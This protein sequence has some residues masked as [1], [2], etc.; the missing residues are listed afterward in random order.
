MCLYVSD[1]ILKLFSPEILNIDS[2]PYDSIYLKLSGHCFSFVIGCIYRPPAGTSLNS[3]ENDS[4]FYSALDSCFK[5][6]S[7]IVL[8]GDFNYPN[9]KWGNNLYSGTN[10]SENDFI[11]TLNSNNITQLVYQPTRFRQF[12]APS[13]LDLVLT[14]DPG[15]VSRVECGC[16]VG[17]SDHCSIE[18]DIQV[19]NYQCSKIETKTYNSISYDNVN[20]HLHA[21]DWSQ[22]YQLDGIEL[23]WNYFLSLIK[24][25]VKQNTRVHQVSRAFRKPWISGSLI[26]RVRH[27][28]RLWIRYKRTN[29]SDDYSLHRLFANQLKIDINDAREKFQDSLTDR[30]KAFYGYLRKHTASRVSRPILRNSM[31]NLCSSDSEAA[32]LLA[33]YFASV[34]TSSGGVPIPDFNFNKPQEILSSAKIDEESLQRE[35][36]TLSL[37]S[38]PGPDGVSPRII[39]YCAVNLVKPMLKMFSTSMV[40]GRL[41]GAWLEAIV[42]PIFKRGDK[43]NCENYRPVSLTSVVCKIMEK[44]I[45]KC[46]L[47]YLHDHEL[48]PRTQHGFLPGRSAVTNL[49]SSVNMWTRQL[50]AGHTVDVVYLDF[51]KA[52]DRVPHNLLLYKL[53]RIGI[54]GCLL[55]WIHGFLSERSFAV[56]VGGSLS[57]AVRVASGVP[58]GSVLGPLLFVLYTVDL[59]AH[60]GCDHVAYADDLKI[61][62]P[63][64]E[65]LSRI[66]PSLN[67]VANWCSEWSLP[68]NTD[69]CS[70]LYL[71]HNNP[72]NRYCLD[73]STNVNEV[74]SQRDLGVVIDNKLS[75]SEQCVSASRRA[76]A[77]FYNLKRIFKSP[78]SIICKRLYTTYIRPHLE[79]ASPVWR[80][81]LQKDQKMLDRVQH[82]VT[83]WPLDFK[84]LQYSDRLK[85]MNLPSLEARQ[86]RSDLVQ[87][88]RIIN[89]LL[90]DGRDCFL[91]IGNSTRLRGHKFKMR[92][93]PFRTACRQRFLTNRVFEDWNALSPEVVNARD[94]YQ[95]K[96]KLEAVIVTSE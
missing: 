79:Y 43:C 12:N 31:G 23:Q 93:E 17:I 82:A 92:K 28:K 71:G 30:P 61:Y 24:N 29:S 84:L 27:K 44:L 56:R 58:Q 49:L 52:F 88:Y 50:D 70:V 78:S 25:V 18:V 47:D 85:K 76:Y 39:K 37:T 34:F 54:G 62:G 15:L 69:K 91:V 46:I 96:K 6:F 68:I 75:W 1:K 16:P 45:A 14:S 55:N 11:Y 80:P 36:N 9:I 8:V 59:L 60:L 26:S 19:I 81:H 35:I 33:T 66:Q 3:M 51:S 40:S 67:C 21:H 13:T 83:R 72:K 86:R 64:S 10:S 77:V 90:P 48:I 22:F 57:G 65:S 5:M 94:V 7:N 41:P 38:A 74:A 63:S 87:T 20:N 73:G 4:I 32:D 89:D 2:G 42:T 53:S 95:F